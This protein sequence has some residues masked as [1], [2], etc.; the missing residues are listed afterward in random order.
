MTTNSDTQSSYL[1]WQNTPFSELTPDDLYAA[2]QLRQR[3]FV[4][5]Q[6]CV[7]LDLDD[8]DQKADHLLGWDSSSGKRRLVAYARLLPPGVKY[9][10]PSIGRVITH[11]DFRGTGAGRVLMGEAV[12]CVEAAG[13]GSAIYIAAQLYLERFYEGFGFTRASEPYTEDDIWHVDMRR[14]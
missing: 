7:Y 14:A 8:A 5:E 9:V 11:P 1:T 13:W 6:K 10:E 4:V 2:L 3:V 12:R